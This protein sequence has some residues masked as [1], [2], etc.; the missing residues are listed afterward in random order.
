ME[1]GWEQVIYR[2]QEAEREHQWKVL[3]RSVLTAES[4]RST[5]EATKRSSEPDFRATSIA[6]VISKH[7]AQ[8]P[9][10]PGSQRRDVCRDCKGF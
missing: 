4:Y 6:C 5:R 9:Q 1:V 7:T 10:G 3:G 2:E 8:L